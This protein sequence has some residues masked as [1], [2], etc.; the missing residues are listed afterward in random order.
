M[1]RIV[2]AVALGLWSAQAGAAEDPT[3]IAL[4]LG[5]LLGSEEA[6]GL[7]FDQPA[8][9]AF[10]DKNAPADDMTFTTTMNIFARPMPDEIAKM[11]VS[12]RTAH[13]AQMRRV[14]KAFGFVK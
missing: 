7:A 3:R 9:E 4:S 12:Q 1:K 10:I 5:E 14:A 13:C 11:S 8:I 6:C 2:V